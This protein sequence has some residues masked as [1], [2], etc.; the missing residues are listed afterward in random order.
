MQLRTCVYACF[1][2]LERIFKMMQ[3]DIIAYLTT[4]SNKFAI[5]FSKM[6]IFHKYSAF[7]IV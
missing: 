1:S 2:N 6:R 4:D 5:N 3:E 7:N